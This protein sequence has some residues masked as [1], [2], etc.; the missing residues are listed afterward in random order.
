M[1]IE[2]RDPAGERRGGRGEVLGNEME[3]HCVHRVQVQY[4]TASPTVVWNYNVPM[5]RKR[6]SP[7]EGERNARTVSWL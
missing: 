4:A 7:V 3:L 1:E 6:T 5:K 2:R